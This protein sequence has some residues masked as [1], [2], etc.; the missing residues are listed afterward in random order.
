MSRTRKWLAVTLAAAGALIAGGAISWWLMSA[1]AKPAAAYQTTA[2]RRGDVSA[3]VTATGTLSPVVLVQVGSQVSGTIKEL[4][5][6]FNSRVTAGQVIARL[7][8]RFF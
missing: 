6:D 5:A 8:P 3:Q 2:I 1:R 7:D 4:G